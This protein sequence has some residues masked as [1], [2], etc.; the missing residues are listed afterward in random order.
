MLPDLLP[1]C[2]LKGN[3]G[4]SGSKLRAGNMR[5]SGHNLYDLKSLSLENAE[6]VWIEFELLLPPVHPNYPEARVPVSS[7]VTLSGC[8]D[9]AKKCFPPYPPTFGSYYI[10]GCVNLEEA[11]PGNKWPPITVKVLPG[12]RQQTQFFF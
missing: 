4:E 3:M 8:S 5:R 6:G 1:V 2:G 12:S 11:S 10:L 7:T 9:A